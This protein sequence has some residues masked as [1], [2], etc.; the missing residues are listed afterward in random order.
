[1]V[2]QTLKFLQANDPADHKDASD[3]NT[4]IFFVLKK[5]CFD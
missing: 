4:L 1:M 2:A 5:L 3:Y